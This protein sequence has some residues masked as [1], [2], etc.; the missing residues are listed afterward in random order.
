[1]EISAF[2]IFIEAVMLIV[3]GYFSYRRVPS[4]NIADQSGA[5]KNLTELNFNLQKEVGEARRETAETRKEIKELR[6]AQANRN[7]S[8]TVIFGVGDKPQVHSATI[9]PVEIANIDLADLQ[10]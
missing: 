3:T 6:D 5:L 2:F 1:M 10:M 7:Y 4:Q 8:L 9:T